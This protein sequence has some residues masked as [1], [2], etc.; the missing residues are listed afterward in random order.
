[1]Q[2]SRENVCGG[3]DS[4]GIFSW[5]LHLPTVSYHREHAPDEGVSFQLYSITLKRLPFIVKSL[6]LKM[7][8]QRLAQRGVI[9]RT[10]TRG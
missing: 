10:I 7:D 8:H 4:P 2:C 3:D 6:L 1:M 9:G 5:N